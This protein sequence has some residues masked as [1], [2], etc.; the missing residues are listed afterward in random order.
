MGKWLNELRQ[1]DEISGNGAAGYRQ[2]RQNLRPKPSEEGSVSSVSSL[3]S[4][5]A[6]FSPPGPESQTARNAPRTSDDASRA[7]ERPP[8][9]S[10]ATAD[11][12]ES[13]ADRFEERAALIEYGAGVPREWAEGFARLDLA[14]PPVGFDAKRWRT[15]IDDGGKFLDRWGGEAA[16]L[17]WSVLD[18]FGAHPVAPAYRYDAAGLVNLISGGDVVDIRTDRAVIRTPSGTSLTYYLR[19]DCRDAVALWDLGT[20]DKSAA[21]R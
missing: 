7:P 15:L 20:V 13:A 21:R 2:N 5:F 18:L 4:R 12:G 11:S 17:G 16:R 19:R 8:N 9:R 6:E 3:P 1:A 10:D 14:S